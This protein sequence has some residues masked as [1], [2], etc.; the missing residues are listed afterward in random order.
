MHETYLL[1]PEKNDVIK[2]YVGSDL[3]PIN[4]SNNCS[5]E[6]AKEHRWWQHDEIK[7]LTLSGDKVISNMQPLLS[8][9]RQQRC[10]QQPVTEPE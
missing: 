8:N 1:T 9:P 4:Q 3:I 7:S 6:D 2:R 10:S 5:L